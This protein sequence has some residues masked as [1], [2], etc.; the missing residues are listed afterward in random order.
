MS[1]T[2]IASMFVLTM[3]IVGG[4][5]ENRSAAS[6][7]GDAKLANGKQHAECLV[8]KRENDLA[9]VDVEVTDTTPRATINGKQYYFCSDSCKNECVKHPD[10]YIVAGK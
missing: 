3:L 6:S 4:C 2:I 9:C 7:S 1:R 8:C 5:T 10:K